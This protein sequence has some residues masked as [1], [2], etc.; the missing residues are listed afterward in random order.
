VTDAEKK[1]LPR[2]RD[3]GLKVPA[4]RQ[5]LSQAQ[6][7]AA[8][9]SAGDRFTFA[10]VVNLI[11]LP[12]NEYIREV[13]SG[14]P[15]EWTSQLGLHFEMILSL[16]QSTRP[17]AGE[18]LTMDEWIF[19]LRG[20][21]K[22]M[23]G[24]DVSHHHILSLASALAPHSWATTKASAQVFLRSSVVAKLVGPTLAL[25]VSH[26]VLSDTAAT[27]VPTLT[28]AELLD[29]IKQ[30][31]T[32]TLQLL[33]APTDAQL[34][35]EQ[36]DRPAK[37]LRRDL[38]TRKELWA[39]KTAQVVNC[40]EQRLTLRRSR[41]T[42]SAALDLAAELQLL[43]G[44]AKT[45]IRSSAAELL[46]SRWSLTRHLLLLDGAVDRYSTEKHWRAREAGRLAGVALA[47][48]ESPPSQPRFQ[49]LRFQITVV[50]VGTYKDLSEWDDSP[51][52]PMT[53]TSILTDINHCPT[54][55][56]T[57]VFRVVERQLEKLG[58]NTYD[59]VSGTGDGGGEN[60]GEHGLHA[61][62]EAL[63][64]GY[65]R[66]RCL[67][68]IAWRTADMALAQAKDLGVTYKP[69]CVYL[70]DGITWS[71]LR[72]IAVNRQADGG[73]ALF[74]E[75]SQA[76]KDV[77]GTSPG[78][79][80]DGRPESDLAFLQILKGKEVT[81]HKLCLR[82][83][84][85]RPSLC[86][87]TATA[88]RDLG[89]TLQ[90]L[91]RVVLAE[92]VERALFLARWNSRH[93]HLIECTSWEELLKTAT[94]KILDLTL[95]LETAT[96]MGYTE[97]QLRALAPPPTTWVELA[98]LETLG[99]AS[100]VPEHLV[101]LLEFH[102]T[103]ASKAAAH[104]ALI[105]ENVL[106]TTWQAARLLVK[107]P[108]DAQDAAKALLKH[109]V[110]TAPHKRTSFE[111]QLADTPTLMTELELFSK[112]APP[113]RLWHGGGR[114]EQLF[115]FL[116]PRFLLAPDHVLD[117][118]RVHA[119]WQWACR[120]KRSVKLHTLNSTLRLTQ[121]LENNH[122]PSH[123]DLHDFLLDEHEH[124]TR[125]L[126]ATAAADVALGWRSDESIGTSVNV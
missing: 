22:K 110:T 69:L 42:V 41:D 3:L 64:P 106:R 63:S 99:D 95:T 96:K 34:A 107:T 90:R 57:D 103:V 87:T 86:P 47:T 71:R 44:Y 117:C 113:V 70:T 114:Y 23:A 25:K 37:R 126:A 76:C 29:D 17:D 98:A 51:D 72:A 45:W 9:I 35:L 78:P 48:D 120:T 27:S 50:Y 118:E 49:G 62:F 97:Q 74:R 7:G 81:L 123:E 82:D 66:R 28:A 108:R 55:K 75:G 24:A 32:N 60:E 121:Y 91:Q 39:S 56:G 83:L 6:R 53:C 65:V 40:L 19:Y 5:L 112:A 20:K 119:R 18:T 59:V 54:K 94:D 4:R 102:R 10:H 26:L 1:V 8:I 100:L 92:I 109:L 67:A 21:L 116:A 15:Q 104:L 80:V 52:P 122:W 58:L 33:H 85:Q 68:H 125:S 2:M 46:H 36:Q 13:V 84:E 31:L 43:H 77:F 12:L 88:V 111:A 93:Q 73:L 101:G 38:A 16:I 105:S 89:S 14:I 30:D 115:R 11:W 61:Q 79:V 124:Y